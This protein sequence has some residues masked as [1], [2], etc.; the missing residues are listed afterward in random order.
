M[1]AALRPALCILLLA[2]CSGPGLMPHLAMRTNGKS[3]ATGIAIG[4][5]APEIVG[6]DVDGDEF[7]LSDYR[8]KVVLL[9][10]TGYS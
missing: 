8:G 6:K 7:K 10:F 1:R 2:G 3:S 4:T 5:E 9:D